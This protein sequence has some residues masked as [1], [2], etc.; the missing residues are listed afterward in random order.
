MANPLGLLGLAPN[1]R[2][3][4]LGCAL[5][6]LGAMAGIATLVLFNR[7]LAAPARLDS[8]YL[9]AC[10]ALIGALFAFSVL[11]QRLIIKAGHQIVRD[12]RL[13]LVRRILATDVEHLDTLGG[14]RILTSLTKDVAAV[15]QAFNSLPFVLFGLVI[16][17]SS[18]CY[19]FWLSLT[20]ALVLLGMTSFIVVVANAFASRTRRYKQAARNA[21]DHIHGAFEALISGRNELALSETRQRSFMK[22]DVE[23][24]VEQ[25]RR[26]EMLADLFSVMTANF[27]NAMVLLLVL[28]ILSLLY[29]SD[30]GGV[31]TALAATT[32]ILFIR[33]PLAG[34]IG[35]LPHFIGGSVAMRRIAELELAADI[36]RGTLVPPLDQW[37]DLRVSALTYCYPEAGGE[38][39]FAF[40]PADFILRQ[41]EII[42]IIGG[43]G[44]GKSTF[45][46]LLTGLY[47]PEEGSMTIGGIAVDDANRA[48]YRQ[49]FGVVLSDYHLFADLVTGTDAPPSAD[50]IDA[51][52][53]QFGLSSKAG[54]ENGRFGTTDLSQGQRKRLALI[55]ALV[56]DRS[57]LLLD[58][59]AADQDPEFRRR[60]YLELLPA[61]KLQGKTIVAITHD[62][63]YFAV[64]DRIY[65]MENGRLESLEK[66]PQQEGATVLS[67]LASIQGF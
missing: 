65:R 29:L 57:I 27:V 9:L 44:S 45:S 19:L 26:A 50:L 23:P 56:E 63:H 37:G 1:R 42:F 59:W 38:P 35:S 18:Y 47:R 51:L 28:A 11:S 24:A 55:S 48:W 13:R 33:A 3:I 12:L 25:G 66:L 21:D 40:G 67:R 36:G 58:E 10:L 5:N 43:N 20:Y 34:L 46:R 2:D 6:L 22:G 53:E 31:E 8:G 49:H 4:V 62:D 16:L 52:I 14:T 32:T 54:V 7:A 64:A 17:L 41:G 30:S 61:L 15:A 39:G 60:F